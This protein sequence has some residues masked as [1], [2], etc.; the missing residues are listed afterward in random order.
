ATTNQPGAT[1]RVIVARKPSSPERAK[2]SLVLI[3][4]I[5]FSSHSLIRFPNSFDITIS[6]RQRLKQFIHPTIAIGE[7]IERDTHLVEQGQM[8]IRQRSWLGIFNVPVAFHS[9]CRAAR[10]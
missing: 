4:D 2:Q 1:P 8:Q 10:N 6:N 5:G 7:L 3:P 9:G